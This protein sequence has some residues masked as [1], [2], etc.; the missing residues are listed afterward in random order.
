[1]CATEVVNNTVGYCLFVWVWKHRV[2]MIAY[3]GMGAAV[4][5]AVCSVAKVTAQCAV[6]LATDV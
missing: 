2:N 4:I 1:M 6:T 5:E 3:D